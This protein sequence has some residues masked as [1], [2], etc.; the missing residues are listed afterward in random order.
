MRALQGP[1]GPVTCLFTTARAGSPSTAGRWRSCQVTHFCRP[2][3]IS[4]G[5]PGSSLRCE[6]HDLLLG[7]SVILEVI[8]VHHF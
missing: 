1:N 5:V 4:S 3:R 6:R 2:F 8:N 7:A